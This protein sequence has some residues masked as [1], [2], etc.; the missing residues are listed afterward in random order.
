[1][2]SIWVDHFSDRKKKGQQNIPERYA[3]INSWC[4]MS[5]AENLQTSV[6]LSICSYLYIFYPT[7]EENSLKPVLHL[8]LSSENTRIEQNSSNYHTF[9]NQKVLGPV[10]QS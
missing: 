6:A 7:H 10:V 8:I 9:F 2:Q 3:Y 5:F 1:M 4:V